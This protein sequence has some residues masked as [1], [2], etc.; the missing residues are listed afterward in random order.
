MGKTAAGP[1]KKN[2]FFF[3]FVFVFVFVL[4]CF[5]VLCFYSGRMCTGARQAPYALF[6]GRAKKG[7]EE[8]GSYDNRVS[9]ARARLMRAEW[10]RWVKSTSS[11]KK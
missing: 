5:L 2:V 9:G 1:P 10:G 8:N 7:R 6:V 4:F 3:C 11:G